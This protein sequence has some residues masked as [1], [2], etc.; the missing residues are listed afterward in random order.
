MASF[1]LTALAVARDVAPAL[2]RAYIGNWDSSA[3]LTVARLLEC[4]QGDIQLTTAS[5][6]IVAAAHA[7][8]MRVVG[9]PCNTDAELEALTEWGVDAVTTDVPSRLLRLT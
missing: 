6:E 9:W 5:P 4:K 1:D 8:G 3:A 7:E 2:P